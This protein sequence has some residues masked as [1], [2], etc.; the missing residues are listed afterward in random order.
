MM[1]DDWRGLG[2]H[3][4]APAGGTG[5][6]HSRLFPFTAIGRGTGF[7]HGQ[8]DPHSP[9]GLR[10]A[11]PAAAAPAAGQPTITFGTNANRAVVSSSTLD[12]L[13]DILRAAGESKA[14]ITSTARTPQDQARAMYANCEADLARQKQLYNP[15][16]GG[17]VIAA[18]EEAKKAKKSKAEIIAAMEAK[19]REIG[20]SKV[21]KHC[22]DPAVVGVI[23]VAPSSITHKQA[24]IKAVA[25]DSRVSKFLKPPNDPAYHLEIRRARAATKTEK[26]KAAEPP[27]D[28][29]RME[30][31][32]D[33][34]ID[35][36]IDTTVAAKALAEASRNATPFV[37]ACPG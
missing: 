11:G 2:A 3:P 32:K 7:L 22:A 31:V 9:L 29:P 23:D 33:T 27:S 36:P 28:I 25:A 6:G 18:Y 17:K 15:A 13:K 34:S 24:F 30:E 20:P 21:S 16:T 35:A 8:I 19:I 5:P 1:A 26:P 37:D 10:Q 4:N 12:V 14:T